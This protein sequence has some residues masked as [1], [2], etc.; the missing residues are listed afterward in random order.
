[1]DKRTRN[2]IVIGALAIVAV[3]IFFTMLYYLL[4]N[5]V[6]KAGTNVVVLMPDGAGL[7]RADR[8]QYQGVAVG[9]VKSIELNPK[10]AGVI[11]KLRL[12]KGLAL[13]KDS[14]VTVSGDVFGAHT[15]AV[16]NGRAAMQL[17]NGDTIRGMTTPLLT[18]IAS[19]LS[20]RA[21]TLLTN[22]D[23]LLSPSAIRD[24]HAT[25]AILPSTATEMRAALAEIRA[26]GASLRRSM[27][28]LEKAQAGPALGNAVRSIDASAQSIK[29]ASDN[30][31]TASSSLN[32]SLQ[33][34]NSVMD[35]VDHGRGTLG[36]LV[37]DSSLYV[38]TNEAMREIRALAQDIRERP[39][40]YIDL[41]L[42]GH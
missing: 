28:D 16:M 19:N 25:A 36:L 10:G 12:D 41:K 26:A 42:F 8:V 17:Q 24:L 30:I 11:V 4:G 7:K 40:R 13:T 21:E 18:D 9:S 33:R 27:Q 23:S 38:E 14:K 35:K 39:S 37:N 29:L 32:T 6:L 20:S 31:A 5:N 34:L 2:P 22:A 1:M 3:I 15:V